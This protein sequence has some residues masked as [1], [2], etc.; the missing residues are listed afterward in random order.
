MQLDI[1]VHPTY[2]EMP[3]AWV[4]VLPCQASCEKR[5]FHTPYILQSEQPVF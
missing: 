3:L 1:I 4:G 5:R 2:Q